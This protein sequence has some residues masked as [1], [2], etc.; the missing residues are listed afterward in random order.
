MNHLTAI[1]IVDFAPFLTQDLAAKQL[2][3]QQIKQACQTY[4]F[5]YLTGYRLAAARIEQTFA[6]AKSFFALPTA[7]KQQVLRS[8]QTNC[9]YVPLA[10]ER[11][12]P[13]RAW[14]LKEAF[15]VGMQT[16]WPSDLEQFRQVVEQ[17]YQD[18][19]TKAALPLLEA[20]AL[21]LHLPESFLVERHGQN[22]FLRLLHY[23]AW[24]HPGG[25]NQL[26]AGEHTD[27][28][29]ITLLFQEHGATGGLEIRSFQGDWLPVPALDGAIVVNIGDAL[30]R[31]TND[32]WH[33][34]PHR[35]VLPQGAAIGRSRY[36]MALFCDP[37]PEVEI[38]CLDT[39]R[40]QPPRYPPV[41]FRDY[42]QS[43][44]AA[45]Y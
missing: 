3:A 5:F 30:Q 40:N 14:D 15:N 45:T 10:A 25:T 8:P 37:N 27:Y 31:W 36:S 29:T 6:E 43:R 12:N 28:G 16:D 42:L 38:A 24:P 33:S 19:I 34:T 2:V 20:I 13:D 17:F 1:P 41:T 21:A 39:C 7:V 9:G 26:R 23:P 44:F 32:D 11:L 35:V 22:F 4:G 18:C